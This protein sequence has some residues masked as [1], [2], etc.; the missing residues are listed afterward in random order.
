[1][2]DSISAKDLQAAYDG[3]FFGEEAPKLSLTTLGVLRKT[4]GV[5]AGPQSPMGKFL[6]DNKTERDEEVVA[7]TP[8]RIS[9]VRDGECV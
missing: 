1:M 7:V 6:E 2:G 8:T 4:L 5:W 3:A 9:I